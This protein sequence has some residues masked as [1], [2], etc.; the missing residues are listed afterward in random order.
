ML[1]A[2][3]TDADL[4]FTVYSRP[5]NIEKI[6]GKVTSC[7]CAF[8]RAATYTVEKRDD[9]KCFIGAHSLSGARSKRRFFEEDFCSAFLNWNEATHSVFRGEI[10]V[11]SSH[12]RTAV[13]NPNIVSLKL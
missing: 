1:R 6:L 12:I 3:F 9:V 11:I 8:F 4:Q 7:A 10:I 13:R 5:K 2:V